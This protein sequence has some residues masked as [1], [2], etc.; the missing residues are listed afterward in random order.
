MNDRRLPTV[1]LLIEALQQSQ[2]RDPITGSDHGL[3]DVMDPIRALHRN[4][5][6]QW[7]REDDAR[8]DPGNDSVV[9]SAKH[10]IDRMNG[11]RHGLIEAVDEA[12]ASMIDRRDEA[13]LVTESPG[14]AIDRLSVLLIRL[15]STEARAA[16][17]SADAELFAERL[18]R[19]HAQLDA[20]QEAIAL[21]LDDLSRGN[22]T[23]FAYESLKLYGGEDPASVG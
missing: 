22:R 6:S 17:E 13:P 11:V 4:N 9:A 3:S 14:M 12:I 21:L 8:K 15:A 16:S 2:V 7:D 20:L 18:P 5:R 23:F 10:D 1:P 19:L